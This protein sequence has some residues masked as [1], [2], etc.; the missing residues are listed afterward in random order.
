M[1]DAA[2]AKT[3]DDAVRLN[4]GLLSPTAIATGA[5]FA[6]QV[7]VVV[8]A[9]AVSQASAVLKVNLSV[10]NVNTFKPNNY[11]TVAPVINI[12]PPVAVATQVPALCNAL[13]FA[14]TGI[15][16]TSYG[17][18][19]VLTFANRAFRND[20]CLAQDLEPAVTT[21]GRLL[22]EYRGRTGIGHE[23][24]V[25]GFASLPPARLA[26][27]PQAERPGTASCGYV[28][29]LHDTLHI[30][31]CDTRTHDRNV[32]LSAARARNVAALLEKEGHGAVVV[33]AI[34]ARGTDTARQRD[35]GAPVAGD[36]TVVIRLRP[37][38][39]H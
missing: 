13:D 21:I 36:Q 12:A 2:S 30:G 22:E 18:N 14:A 3:I 19:S 27:C 23:A 31:S 16:C 28:N 5:T 35:A 20:S 34:Q 37:L 39:G 8:A 11:N 24:T 4:P 10:S 1:A 38:R 9:N 29:V 25:E 33:S 26:H 17:A 15:D 7:N 6:D 32:V